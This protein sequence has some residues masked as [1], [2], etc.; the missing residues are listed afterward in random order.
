MIWVECGHTHRAHASRVRPAAQ[1][2]RRRRTRSRRRHRRRHH[3]SRRRRRRRRRRGRRRRCSRRHHCRSYV[4]VTVVINVVRVSS[5]PS[6]SSCDAAEGVG[7]RA[8]GSD[9]ERA[10]ILFYRT[11]WQHTVAQRSIEL[12]PRPPRG[13]NQRRSDDG[14]HSTDGKGATTAAHRSE[15]CTTQIASA[16]CGV[17]APHPC[18]GESPSP[19]HLRR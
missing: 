13:C 16:V 18:V 14:Q 9:A 2:R 12:R 1:Y 8:N 3:R 5:P 15:I 11:A 10:R 17:P 7:P 4:V 19:T 6:A